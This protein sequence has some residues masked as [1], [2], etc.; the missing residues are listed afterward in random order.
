MKG[1]ITTI[2]F[3]L[4]TLAKADSSINITDL[5]LA[6]KDHE[7]GVKKL[8]SGMQL[9][10]GHSRII[11]LNRDN[12]TTDLISISSRLLSAEERA[13]LNIDQE[14]IELSVKYQKAGNQSSTV[15]PIDSKIIVYSGIDAELY[16]ELPNGDTVIHLLIHAVNRTISNDDPLL[17]ALNN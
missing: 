4:S 16:T 1:F 7:R 5:S 13:R 15:T 11:K 10:N 6:L 2:F 12:R 8:Y 14:L 17:H 3:F 9:V